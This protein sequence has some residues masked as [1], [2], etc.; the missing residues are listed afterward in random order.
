[1]YDSNNNITTN[2]TNAV[3]IDYI[4]SLNLLRSQTLQNEKFTF[5]YFNYTG[6]FSQRQITAHSS[7]ISGTFTLLINNTLIDPY[8][9][10]T[11]PYNVNAATLQTY[12]NT[13]FPGF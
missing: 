2:I 12:L 3:Q 4:A 9:N 5:R 7:L 1:M 6:T 13:N 11:L 10:G 8:G